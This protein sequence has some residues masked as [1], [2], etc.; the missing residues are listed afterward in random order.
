MKREIATLLDHLASRRPARDEKTNGHG[1][2]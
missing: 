2:I 1:T